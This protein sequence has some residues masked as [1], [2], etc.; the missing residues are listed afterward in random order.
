MGSYQWRRLQGRRRAPSDRL[1]CSRSM[2]RQKTDCSSSISSSSRMAAD[3]MRE[4]E[5]RHGDRNREHQR[6]DRSAEFKAAL[7]DRLVEQS[8]RRLRIRDFRPVKHWGSLQLK[9]RR[10]PQLY[11]FPMSGFASR[12][13]Q[14]LP[15]S[16]RPNGPVSWK[17]PCFGQAFPPIQARRGHACR[18]RVSSGV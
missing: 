14:Q 7:G 12:P 11:E 6:S 3:A 2:R 18:S 17:R 13:G 8:R 15:S 16:L 5:D 1:C 10:L 4:N 9:A